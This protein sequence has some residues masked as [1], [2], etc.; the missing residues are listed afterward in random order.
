[1]FGF[2][3]SGQDNIRDDEEEQFKAYCRAIEG[4]KDWPVFVS[5][6]RAILSGPVRRPPG[7]GV[8]V[9]TDRE[10]GDRRARGRSR[11]RRA[12]AGA[13]RPQGPRARRQFPRRAP[14][15]QGRREGHRVHRRQRKDPG[16]VLSHLQHF[17]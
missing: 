12:G 17:I 15:A 16:G 4:M 5:A 1:M 2:P 11:R 10:V 9:H 7:I 14:K 3:K 6:V 8:A 13:R